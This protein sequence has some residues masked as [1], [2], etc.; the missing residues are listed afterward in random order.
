[1][2][3]LKDKLTR[4]FTGTAKAWHRSDGNL[5]LKLDI[6]EPANGITAP[7]RPLYNAVGVEKGAHIGYRTVPPSVYADQ[8]AT[9]I[10]PK[11]TDEPPAPSLRV[12]VGG[13]AVHKIGNATNERHA[14][15]LATKAMLDGNWRT[16][17]AGLWEYVNTH[18]ATP[19]L[20]LV[21]PVAA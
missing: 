9:R 7:Q 21:Q 1:M 2:W 19:T 3:N 8:T 5:D 14:T 6:K 20:T 17:L 15:N 18:P 11:I 4:R 16:A 12:A 13:L 10:L